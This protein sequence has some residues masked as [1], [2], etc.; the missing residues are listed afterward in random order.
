MKAL[1]TGPAQVAAWLVGIVVLFVSSPPRVE[2][3]DSPTPT[4]RLIQFGLTV[5]A[6]LC[7]VAFRSRNEAKHAKGWSWAAAAAL[8]A[9]FALFGAY[10]YVSDHWTCQYDARAPMVTGSAYLPEAATYVAENPG[11]SCSDLIADYGGQTARIWDRGELTDRRLA[12]VGLFSLTVTAF[13]LAALF[14]LQALRSGR[15]T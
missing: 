15:R 2:I 11:L 5:V 4:L 12:L 3:A 7:F 9:A 1:W 10:S 13:V 6:G 8:L 14:M